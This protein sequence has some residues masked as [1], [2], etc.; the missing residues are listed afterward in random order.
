MALDNFFRFVSDFK[1]VSALVG[2]AAL[3][4]PFID[5]LLNIGPPWPGKT[6]VPALT[7]LTEVFVLIY[8]FQFYTPL[9]KRRLEKRL[10]SFFIVI[11]ACFLAYISLYSFFVYEAA[12]TKQRDVKGFIVREAIQRILGPNRTLERALEGAEWDPLVIWEGWTV[13]TMRISLLV[14]WILF[15]VG[16]VGCIAVFVTL[17]Q[18]AGSPRTKAANAA[19]LSS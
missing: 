19:P 17:Q 9:A 14:A 18:K 10:R 2:K 8:I 15:F 13:Y 7:T 1:S 11:I 4:A 6:S 12:T 16:I 3:L 5:L